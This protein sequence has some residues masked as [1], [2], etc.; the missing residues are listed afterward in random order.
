MSCVNAGLCVENLPST[1][2]ERA[3]LAKGRSQQEVGCRRRTVLAYV[4]SDQRNN[5]RQGRCSRWS[6]SKQYCIVTEAIS[7]CLV[8]A[9]FDLFRYLLLGD[10]LKPWELHPLVSYTMGKRSTVYF[11]SAVQLQQDRFYAPSIVGR[12]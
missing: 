5:H 3:D 12:F 11:N 6:V 1:C 4:R 9:S 10:Q 7:I 8:E 2:L